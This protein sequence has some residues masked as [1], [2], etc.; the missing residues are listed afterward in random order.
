[1]EFTRVS[2]SPDWP[3]GATLHT[4]RNGDRCD[5]DKFDKLAKFTGKWTGTAQHKSDK[6]KTEPITINFYQALGGCSLM[7][8]TEIGAGLNSF[9]EFSLMTFNTFGKKFEDGRLNSELQSNYRAFYGEFTNSN[10]LELS[11]R[12]SSGKLKEVYTWTFTNEDQMRLEQWTVDDDK[13]IK[14]VEARLRKSK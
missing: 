10:Q 8:F 13:K 5:M 9:K 7:S 12:D 4:F 2:N 3:Q 14:T 11:H 1:M 6:D